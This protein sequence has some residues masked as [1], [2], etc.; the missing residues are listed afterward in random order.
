MAEKKPKI[1]IALGGGGA[2]GASHVGILKALRGAEIDIDFIVGTSSGALAGACYALGMSF[3]D[4][5]AIFMG[6]S[7]TKAIKKLM[8]IANPKRSL[9]KGKKIQKYLEELFNHK[10]FSDTKIPLYIIATNLAD[11]SEVVLKDGSICEAIKATISVPGIFPPVEWNGTYLIDGG[12]VNPTPV[13][14]VK[15]F[16]ADIIIGVDL[17]PKRKLDITE[18][19]T[20]VTTLLQ[21]YDII[22]TQAVRYN[23]D[24]V[25]GSAVIIRPEMGGVVESFKFYGMERFFE[26]GM[27]AAEE[28][29]PEIKR[30]IE[31][32]KQKSDSL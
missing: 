24:K 29:I 13:D 7:K 17:I 22:R 11:G 1:G 26:I 32:F 12:V 14:K 4:M 10:Q 31:E 27:K 25:N 19:P 16:G 30:R 2:R 28:K 20:V 5:E 8:D 9:I 18:K 15:E 21:A 6:Y 23:I 3:T